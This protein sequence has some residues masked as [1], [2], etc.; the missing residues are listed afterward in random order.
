ML[1]RQPNR[2]FVADSCSHPIKAEIESRVH[3]AF[4]R[5]V[6]MVI[7]C[8]SL[9]TEP[10]IQLYLVRAHAYARHGER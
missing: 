3:A 7:K 4:V 8:I 5:S 6:N 10:V 2:K 9:F 1:N